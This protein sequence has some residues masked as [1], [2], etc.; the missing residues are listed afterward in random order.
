[1]SYIIIFSL[2]LLLVNAEDYHG[3]TWQ[4]Q[5]ASTKTSKL[6]SAILKDT[7]SAPWPT[8]F[9]SAELLIESMDT[10]FDFVGDDMPH[11]GLFN[12]EVRKK[13]IHSVG[14]VVEARYVSLN[15]TYSGIFRSGCQ[16]VLLRFSIAQQAV[17]EG[18][19]AGIAP[20]IALKFMRDGVPSANVF[21]MYSLL[22]QSNNFN[23]FKHDLSSHVPDLPSDAPTALQLIRWKFS[24]ASAFP[25]FLGLNGIAAYDESGDNSSKLAFPFRLHFHPNTTLHNLLPDTWTGTDFEDQIIK[26][27]YP[28]EN[29]HLYDVYAQDTPYGD[30]LQ[31]IG[32]VYSKAPVTRSKFGDKG[33]FY[34]HTR[35]EDDLKTFPSWR[36]KAQ[37]IMDY[38]RKQTGQGYTYPDLPFH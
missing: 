4:T 19:G 36:S 24:T 2:L 26:I 30:D 32:K 7:Q 38:Q 14:A 37:E 1:M 13:L 18:P 6:D 22:G 17:T 9:E 20:G 3:N 27:I 21:A 33:L 15:K 25:V 29:F 11:Q 31:L 8:A 34:E 12:L 35:F 10:S 5:S 28:A 16:N 23:F